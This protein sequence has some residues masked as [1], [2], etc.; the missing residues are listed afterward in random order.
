MATPPYISPNLFPDY[1]N[2]A[3]RLQSLMTLQRSDAP[4]PTGMEEYNASMQNYYR[5]LQFPDTPDM[6]L[7]TGINPSVG[8][9]QQP[10]NLQEVD[11]LYNEGKISL[12]QANQYE[13]LFGNQSDT[14]GIPSTTTA[15]T[16]ATQR[17]QGFPFINFSGSDL[18]TELFSLG[19][20]IGAPKGTQGRGLGI[21]GSAGAAGLNIARDIAAGIGYQKRNQ[22]AQ[23]YNNDLMNNQ[24][25]TPNP[26][27]NVSSYTGGMPRGEYGGLFR[28]SKYPNGGTID[29]IDPSEMN[30]LRMIDIQ[31]S[32][33][34]GSSLGLE[35][36]ILVT[37]PQEISVYE[38]QTG[39][40]LQGKRLWVTP[41][42]SGS[43]VV[44]V[45]PSVTSQTPQSTI[46]V[47]STPSVGVYR[48]ANTGK[49][50]PPDI[51]GS[52]GQVDYQFSQYLDQAINSPEQREKKEIQM[53]E[54]E[55]NKELL[56]TMTEEQKADMRAKKLTPSQYLSSQGTLTFKNGGLFSKQ[57]GEKVSFKHG[58]KMYSGTI[59]KI[60]NGKIYI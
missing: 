2:L 12:D 23:D 39:Q 9:V 6:A 32:K 28:P 21:I 47:S 18:T 49:I 31:N 48:D 7:P 54:I 38:R 1:T 41:D 60:E 19:A 17:G 52:P 16:N 34:N 59:K 10:Q 20:N 36:T 40:S 22:Y 56:K 13:I 15:Q 25:Y 44:D 14:T 24:R 8:V 4:L 29:G 55:R 30:R 35:G 51:W 57:V 42:R 27:Y 53:L 58:G 37:D 26:Q 33:V 3:Q 50:L 43:Y 11:R 45:N 46:S 5:N